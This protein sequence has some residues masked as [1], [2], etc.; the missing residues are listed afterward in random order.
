MKKHRDTPLEDLENNEPG[1]GTP[2]NPPPFIPDDT[3][4]GPEEGVI[5]LSSLADLQTAGL[6]TLETPPSSPANQPQIPIA[7][8]LPEQTRRVR[9][10]VLPS[11]HV[12]AA[13]THRSDPA[14]LDH[15]MTIN[16]IMSMAEQAMITQNVGQMIVAYRSLATFAPYDTSPTNP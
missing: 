4:E 5:N 13:T 6:S 15:V 8:A 12:A 7:L 16:A 14:V 10:L 9:E 3:G 1:D 2:D 11:W